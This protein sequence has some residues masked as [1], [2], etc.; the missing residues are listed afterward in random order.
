MRISTMNRMMLAAAISLLLS[1]VAFAGAS[2]KL[3][4]D[5]PPYGQDKPIPVP[6]IVKKTL[7]NGWKS[8][9][10][11]A[12]DCRGSTTSWPCAARA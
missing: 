11:R 4:A 5:L 9:L 10:S 6:K 7:S 12:M 2:A 3:P 1:P 8:G